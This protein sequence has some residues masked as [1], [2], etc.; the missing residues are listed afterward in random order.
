LAETQ[1]PDVLLFGLNDFQQFKTLCESDSLKNLPIIVIVASE[2]SKR[3][4]DCLASGAA[5]FIERP[6]NPIIVK[7]RVNIQL[8]ISHQK[9]MI[10]T[11]AMVD[12]LT[13]IPNRIS[14]QNRLTEEWNRAARTATPLT[15]ATVGIDFFKQYN[16]NYGHAKGDEVLKIVASTILGSLKRAAD[17]VAR[18]GNSEFALIIPENSAE[19]AY[20]LLNDICRAI[21]SLGILHEY[22]FE[23][24]LTVSVGGVT[25]LPYKGLMTMRDFVKASEALLDKAKSNGKNTIEW[26]DKSVEEEI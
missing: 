6:F 19:G 3:A 20:M 18:I 16:E 23:K 22:S 14:Y 2:D 25:C 24:I 8:T 10:E 11:L 5:D 9:K 21:R 17:F 13:E 7:T 26:A 1:K 12:S 15:L 4:E